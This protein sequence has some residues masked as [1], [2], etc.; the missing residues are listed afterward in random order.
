MPVDLLIDSDYSLRDLVNI[1]EIINH[2]QQINPKLLVVFLDMCRT[3]P[4]EE[5][6]IR[7]EMPREIQRIT[8]SNLVLLLATSENSP[9]YEVLFYYFW[10][11]ESIM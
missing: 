2:I 1:N 8:R 9:A 4:G 10:N 7:G 11:V 5:R 6:R 3:F